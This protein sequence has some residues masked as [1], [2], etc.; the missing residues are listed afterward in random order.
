MNPE[1][2]IKGKPLLTRVRTS[3]DY[4]VAEDLT[5]RWC[6]Q[7]NSLFR[8]TDFDTFLKLEGLGGR[9]QRLHSPP[10]EV[11]SLYK[12]GVLKGC[13]GCT[14]TSSHLWS[15]YMSANDLIVKRQFAKPPMVSLDFNHNSKRLYTFQEFAEDL[16]SSGMCGSLQVQSLW[17]S[18]GTR[19]RKVTLIPLL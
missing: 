17:N 14:D 16:L 7:G 18:L 15:E 6:T 12:S 11:M 19:I 13:P 4:K 1:T 8:K 2:V 3:D 5:S 9:Y 10:K